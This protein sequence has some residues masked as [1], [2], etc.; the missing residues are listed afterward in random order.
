MIIKSYELKKR[1]DNKIN[2]YLLY[3]VNSG[4]IE[5]TITNIFK[6]NFS[7]NIQRYD[8]NEILG[9]IEQFKETI[10]NKSFF[11]NDKLIIINK[12]SDKILV[13]IEEILDKKIEDLTIIL[14]SNILDKKS[15]LRNFFE[16]DKNVVIIPFYEDNNQ[17]LLYL[18]QNFFKE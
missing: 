11:E 10:F 17:T 5:E 18:A 3:G 13:I 8:E 14:K 15:K 9:N 16:K 4:L 12:T 6:P 2:H 7:K 1:L